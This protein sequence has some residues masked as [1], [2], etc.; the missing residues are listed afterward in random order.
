MNSRCRSLLRTAGSLCLL[1]FTALVAAA[2]PVTYIYNGNGFTSFSGTPTET[3]ANSLTVT[4]VF[5][6]VLPA[7]LSWTDETAGIQSWSVSDGVNGFNQSTP[8]ASMSA[9]LSTDGSGNIAGEWDVSGA[10]MISVPFPIEQLATANCST[11]CGQAQDRFAYSD[12]GSGPPANIPPTSN[13]ATAAANPNGWIPVATSAPEPSTAWLLV[14]GA[15]A[16]LMRRRVLLD[17]RSV[18]VAREGRGETSES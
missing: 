9:I 12:P 10:R 8:G 16:L 11:H 5:A 4:L 17:G 18:E 1:S 7:N 14:P 6:S 15:L 13:T 3:S 2:S